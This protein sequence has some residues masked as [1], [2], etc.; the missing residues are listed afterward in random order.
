MG[1][2][3]LPPGF[4]ATPE[5]SKAINSGLDSVSSGIQE[6]SKSSNPAEVSRLLEKYSSSFQSLQ[7]SI[8]GKASFA[9]SASML[10]PQSYLN[11]AKQFGGQKTLNSFSDLVPMDKVASKLGDAGFNQQKG[12]Q[13]FSKALQGL[14]FDDPGFNPRG[15]SRMDSPKV[16]DP[17]FNPPGKSGGDIPDTGDP[18]FTPKGKK[19]TDFP[20]IGDPGFTPKSKKQTDFPNIGDP[21]FNPPT[22]SGGDIPDI[23]DPGF[24]PPSKLPMDFPNIGDP[25]FTPK[26][27]KQTDFP[28]ISDPGFNPPGKS[29]SDFPG[30]GDAGFNPPSKLP[31]D[32][33]NIGDP[34]FNLTDLTKSQNQDA[35]VNQRLSD[36]RGTLNE[37]VSL[38]DGISG[39]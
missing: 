20:N 17:G 24:N 29:P 15:G 21:G 1:T 4:R 2:G 13:G 33:P 5:Q 12:L 37:M 30:I 22:K 6:A 16:G 27:K 32:F 7:P 38:S 26:G 39:K 3:I 28:N 11:H 18:G 36:F 25:G 35:N 9:D 10:S 34:G 31:T 19:Q 14:E 8:S 23:G